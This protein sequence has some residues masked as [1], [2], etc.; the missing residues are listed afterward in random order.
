MSSNDTLSLSYLTFGFVLASIFYKILDHRAQMTKLAAIPTLGSSGFLSSYVEAFNFVFN[1][2]DIIQEGYQRYHGSAFKVPLLD[3]WLVVVCGSKMIEDIRKAS[4]EQLSSAEAFAEMLQTDITMGKTLRA[5]PYQIGVIL[6]ALTKNIPARFADVHDEIKTAFND[7]IPPGDEWIK[8]PALK[9]VLNIV[10]R[11]TNRMFVGLPL[12]RDPDWMNLNIFFTVNVF[13]RASIINLFPIALQSVIGWLI[14]PR[15]SS[16]RRA[17]RH[18]KPLFDERF[19]EDGDPEQDLDPTTQQ[20]NLM[21]WL[22]REAQGEQRTL[23]DLAMRVLS[24]N[25]AAIHTTSMAFTNALYYLAAD[26]NLVNML[27]EE[28]EAQVQVNGWTK[29]AM[30]GMRKLDSFLKESQRLSGTSAITLNRKAL[31]DFALSDGTV[32]PAGTIVATAALPVHHD[33]RNYS[34]PERFD[35]LRF[36]GIREKEGKS[37][38]H[39]MMT[40]EQGY[41]AFGMGKHACPGRFFAAVELKALVSHTL[42][43]Y[44]LKF[45]DGVTMPNIEWFAATS[46]ANRKGEV[47]FRKRKL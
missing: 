10:C 1:A 25:V 43:M 40:P 37:V 24:V 44:D 2:R 18:L 26:S 35:P 14:T 12:C 6:N 21:L 47:M 19:G 31:S 27:R 28:I 39:Q 38:K 30:D 8:R 22:W 36:Y 32:I 23:E 4:D 3:H 42:M 33:E 15:P 45:D 29:N 46:T 16:L 41:L 11:T 17:V 5:D 34:D 7:E 9:T 20:N 13:A